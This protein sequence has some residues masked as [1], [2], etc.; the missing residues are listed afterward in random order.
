ML[1]CSQDCLRVS[2]STI[3]RAS[4]GITYAFVPWCRHYSLERPSALCS[5]MVRQ[6]VGKLILCLDATSHLMLH[7]VITAERILTD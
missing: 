4:T 1:N 2:Y 3:V 5:H 7:Q 6:A